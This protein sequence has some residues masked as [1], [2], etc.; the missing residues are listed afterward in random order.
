M[1]PV[2]QRTVSQRPAFLH[3]DRQRRRTWAPLRRAR[4]WRQSHAD[5]ASAPVERATVFRADQRLRR[6]HT[7]GHVRHSKAVLVYRIVKVL[8]SFFLYAKPVNPL[9]GIKSEGLQ[10]PT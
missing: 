7:L 5:I 4:A 10:F 6:A 8:T 3:A 9:G 1:S 2:P